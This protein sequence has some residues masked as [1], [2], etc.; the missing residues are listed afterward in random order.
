MLLGYMYLLLTRQKQ[1]STTGSEKHW[2]IRLQ[3]IDE[4]TEDA[5]K[6][7]IRKPNYTSTRCHVLPPSALGRGYLLLSCWPVDYHRLLPHHNWNNTGYITNV[8]G[9]CP[10]LDSKLLLLKTSHIQ[11]Y[12]MYS[13]EAS[14]LMARLHSA[15]RC[16]AHSW[17]RK[18]IISFTQLWTLRDRFK[19]QAA[20][21]ALLCN[22]GM[23]IWE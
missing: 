22:S 1:F 3:I 13:T 14:Y 23:S 6:S 12:N 9:Y 19:G 10:Q 5:Q 20:R 18:V 17:G 15:R 7:G 16:Y 11:S 2:F 21:S 8:I 4:T